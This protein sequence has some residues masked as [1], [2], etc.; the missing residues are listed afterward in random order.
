MIEHGHELVP[1]L[2]TV[3]GFLAVYVLNGIKGEIKEVKT[4]VK[5]LEN[6]LRGGFGSLDRRV[7]ALETRCT[8][9]HEH[10]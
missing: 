1:Y 7:T 8:M 2:L 9:H 5:A 10:E 3:L 6:D 4:T